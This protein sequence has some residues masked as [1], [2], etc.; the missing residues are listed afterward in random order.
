[1]PTPDSS[2]DE[3]V[4]AAV[5]EGLL[6]PAA[7]I[8]DTC[9]YALFYDLDAYKQGHAELR[10]AFPSHWHHA[11]AVKTNPLAAFLKLALSAG[12]GAECA[13]IGEVV[14]ALELGFAPADVVYDSPC[15]SIP[16]LKYAIEKGVHLNID[17]LQ[18]K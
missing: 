13:S 5:A 8:S 17:N 2:I 15:K 14:H 1:M 9:Q 10:A 12:H 18:G 7:D 4:A 6:A 16:E 3:V 11:T